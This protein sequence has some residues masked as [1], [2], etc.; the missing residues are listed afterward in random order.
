MATGMNLSQ[1]GTEMEGKEYFERRGLM[2]D[3]DELRRV[4]GEAPRDTFCSPMRIT[5]RYL[6][7][8]APRP[9]I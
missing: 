7:M 2:G 4:N 6:G 8:S 3:G 9:Q 1:G 5:F